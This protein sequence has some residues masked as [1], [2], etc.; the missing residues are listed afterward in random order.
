MNQ[1]PLITL[2][3]ILASLQAPVVAADV[4]ASR[5]L[6]PQYAVP[7]AGSR[8]A[9]LAPAPALHVLVASQDKNGRVTIQCSEVESAAF[10]S[11][12]ERASRVDVREEKS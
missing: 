2:F 8:D 6:A 12:R 4:P 9:A 7:K 11:W 5:P 10:R 1:I 3:A